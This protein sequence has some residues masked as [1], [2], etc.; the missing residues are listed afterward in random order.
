MSNL[1]VANTIWAQISLST[2][3]ACG[4]R[5]PIGDENSLMF[6]VTITRNVTHKIKVR[7]DPNDTYT[8][9]CY[10]LGRHGLNVTTEREVNDVY[11]EDLSR[12]IYDW[13]NKPNEYLASYQK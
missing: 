11:A 13:C 3:M 5:K 7:L 6:Q 8:L 4:A 10:R 1:Q 9:T 12:I 2:K